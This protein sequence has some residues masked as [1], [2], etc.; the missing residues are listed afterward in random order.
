MKHRII[1]S[2]IIFAVLLGVVFL[3]VTRIPQKE[4]ETDKINVVASFY[5][6]A[7]IATVVGGEF[8]LVRD[9]VPS[10]T[11]PHDFEPS[12]RILAELG[13]SD[14]FLYNGA[15]FEPWVP[16]WE[17]STRARPMRVIN[18]ADTLKGAG[19]SFIEEGGAV[20]P[21]FW[22]DPM[23]FTEEVKI[24][25]DALVAIDPAHEDAFRENA[26]RFISALGNLDQ[27]FRE[28][29]SSCALRDIIVLHE[30]FGYLA[31]RYDFSA[32]AIVGI[33]PEEEPSPKELVRII[34]LAR[35]KGVKHIFSE[36]IASPKFSEAV[37]REI[38]GSTL[39]LNPIESMTPSGVQSKQDYIFAMEMNLNNLRNAMICN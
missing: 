21:H 4:N 19:V 14:L 31:R 25:R 37:A 28:G 33:S 11:E 26:E 29:L 1:F 17:Q 9:L 15:G 3:C 22:L 20:N 12:P 27:H 5:P 18:M 7:H 39:V 8:V 30:A 38:G 16:K 6:L 10:G 24:V 35:E 23:I 13:R 2:I 32:T 36:T 34:T